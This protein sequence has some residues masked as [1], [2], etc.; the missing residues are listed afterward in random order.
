MEPPNKGHMLGLG[1]FFLKR[2][3][4]LLEVLHGI[5]KQACWDHKQY[6]LWME[7]VNSIIQ[8]VT[9]VLAGGSTLYMDLNH[10]SNFKE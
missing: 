3:H 10:R 4:P 7:L 1:F 9:R 5:A 8:N 6:V 2:V